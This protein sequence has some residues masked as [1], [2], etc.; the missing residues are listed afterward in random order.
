MKSIRPLL[1]ASLAFGV[2]GQFGC[3]GV[4]GPSPAQPT[5]SQPSSGV[6]TGFYGPALAADGLANTTL[7]PGGNIVSYRIRARHTGVVDQIR[8]Y[9]IPDHSGYAAGNGGTI[10]VTLHPD[11]GAATHNPGSTVLAT[12]VIRNVL[13]LPSPDR[14]FYV[15]K[16]ASP[17]TLTA[18]DLYHL[19]FRNID[20]NPSVNYL[21]VD[22][23]YEVTPTTPVQPT[24][25]DMDAAVLLGDSGNSWAPRRGYTPIYELDFSNGTTE[26]VGYIEGWIGAPQFI[27]GANA[28]RETFTVA[29]SPVTV[30]SVAVRVARVSGAG[31]LQLRLENADGSVIEEVAVPATQVRESNATNPYYGWMK[32]TFSSALTL[33][34][35]QTY[36]LDLEAASSS[37]YMAFPIRKGGQYGFDTNTYFPDGHAEFTQNGSWVGWTQWGATNRTDGEL[38]FYFAP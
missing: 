15:V 8:I 2:L 33:F 14:Y 35:G 6:Q 21:S 29:G 1:F 20:S 4:A 16:F 26:G 37:E 7:G 9:L 22:D 27:S 25:N 32:A 36:H 23:L 3:A 24:M 13:S 10:E 28:V 38:Q 18:G 5:Q 12:Y 19:V 31:P 17:P 30:S 34:H 11:D